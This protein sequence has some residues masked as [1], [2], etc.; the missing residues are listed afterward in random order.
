MGFDVFNSGSFSSLLLEMKYS[1]YICQIRQKTN[2][3]TF[4]E[5]SDI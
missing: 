4:S 1:G 3:G 5:T 2:S